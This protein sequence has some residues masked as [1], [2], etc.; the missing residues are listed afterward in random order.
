MSFK[1][2]FERSGE[3][4]NLDYDDSAF[5]YFGLAMLNVVLIPATYYLVLKPVLFG[6]FQVNRNMKN[7]KCDLCT[8]RLQKRQAVY[9]YSWL[10]MQ[11]MINLLILAFFWY[12]CYQCFDIVK[13]IEPLKTFIP[14]ELL[15]VES[16]ATP[17]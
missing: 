3:K 14:H 4:E 10:N 15:G 6:E 8:E 12:L 16:D 5:Y 2:S 13:D 7:C 9:R 11:F 1:Q 17:A